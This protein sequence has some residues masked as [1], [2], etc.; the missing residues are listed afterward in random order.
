M[1]QNV[2]FI[3]DCGIPSMSSPKF[4]LSSSKGINEGESVSIQGNTDLSR[5]IMG[6][7]GACV[8]GI[9]LILND[10]WSMWTFLISVDAQGPGV[11]T[12]GLILYFTDQSGDT[13]TLTIVTST[14]TSHS[15]AYNSR[16]PAI[17][18]IEWTSFTTFA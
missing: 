7:D 11:G 17:M 6:Y 2:D 8:Y 9:K 1:S 10:P 5:C 18:T 13:Y 16:Q 12:P 15:V 3:G 4:A 14:R